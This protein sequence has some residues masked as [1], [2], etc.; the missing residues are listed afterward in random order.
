MASFSRYDWRVVAWL[1]VVAVAVLCCVCVVAGADVVA[2]VAET[3]LLVG[4]VVVVSAGAPLVALAAF[5][6]ASRWLSRSFSSCSCCSC[7]LPVVMA[8]FPVA[9]AVVAAGAAL[10]TEAALDEVRCV[11]TSTIVKAPA[12]R[13]K[14][15][16][17]ARLR[18]MAARAARVVDVVAIPFL[19]EC[20]PVLHARRRALGQNWR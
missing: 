6:G 15:A 19:R 20:R 11:E 4:T 17:V 10:A 8:V 9:A 1:R 13:P 5:S 7:A 16:A 3:V 14:L 2:A 18:S 12:R